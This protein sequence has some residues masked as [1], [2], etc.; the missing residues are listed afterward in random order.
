LAA[1]ISLIDWHQQCA[2]AAGWQLPDR[3]GQLWL[4][5]LELVGGKWVGG[6]FWALTVNAA[7]FVER[8]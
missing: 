6:H 5:L 7:K 2:A 1:T 4:T 3:R 8:V